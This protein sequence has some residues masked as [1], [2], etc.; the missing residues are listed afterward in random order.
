[1]RPSE[2]VEQI[3]AHARATQGIYL[4]VGDAE[5]VVALYD[6]LPAV[7]DVLKAA[8]E[9]ERGGTHEGPCLN[10]EGQ[11]PIDYDPFDSCVRHMVAAQERF[12]NLSAA[13]ERL[14]ASLAEITEK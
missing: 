5:Q 13:L 1:M 9:E 11:E 4:K 10:Q 8:E 14:R 6:V 7:V 3:V 2:Q 12:T